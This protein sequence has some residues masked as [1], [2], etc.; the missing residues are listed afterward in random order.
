MVLLQGLEAIL[1]K[2]FIFF[3]LPPNILPFSTPI[4]YRVIFWTDF[5]VHDGAIG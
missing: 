2:Y 3:A 5:S 4:D 1:K